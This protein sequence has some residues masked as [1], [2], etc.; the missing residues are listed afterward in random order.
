M[1][2]SV[3]NILNGNA[4]DSPILAPS[5]YRRM[6]QTE[7]WLSPPRIIPERILFVKI[8]MTDSG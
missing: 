7:K 6:I 2:Q 5:V 4:A 1:D 3:N 8:R